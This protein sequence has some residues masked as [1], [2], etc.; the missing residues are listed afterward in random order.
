MNK[1]GDAYM[2]YGFELAP[3]IN[4]SAYDVYHKIFEFANTMSGLYKN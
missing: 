4:N 2:N 3:I 1:L